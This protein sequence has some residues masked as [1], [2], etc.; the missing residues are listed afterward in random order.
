M[1]SGIVHKLQQK[2]WGNKAV[3]KRAHNLQMGGI[4]KAGEG[5]WEDSTGEKW[6]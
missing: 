5:L 2:M 1:S 6:G 3:F 4:G